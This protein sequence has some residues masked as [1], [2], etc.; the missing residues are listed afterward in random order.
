MSENE[1][2]DKLRT[3]AVIELMGHQRIAGWVEE[4]EIAGAGFLR[5][6]V[7]AT[8]Q[9]PGFT[10]LVS[11]KSVYAITPCVEETALRVAEHCRAAPFQAWELGVPERPALP[12]RAHED[13]PEDFDD[14]DDD[15]DIPI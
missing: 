9:G 2:T 6:D 13:E 10:R 12:A 3:H 4:I 1:N 7:P 14:Q 5:V 11:P 15:E 8:T